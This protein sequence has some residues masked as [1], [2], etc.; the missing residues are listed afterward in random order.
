MLNQPAQSPPPAPHPLPS[1]A[2]ELA[3]FTVRDSDLKV[4]LVQREGLARPSL[5]GA[6][7]HL[8]EGPQDQ[9]EDLDDTARRALVE[10]T[11][12]PQA[13]VYLEQLGAFGKPGRDPSSRVISVAFELLPETFTVA[14][15]REVYEAVFG[16]T[17]DP[18]NFRRRFK[19]LLEDGVVASA[20]GRRQT[21]SKPAAVFRYCGPA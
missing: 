15:L 20:P 14:E 2:A 7:V 16:A 1:V 10:Q 17:Y 12:L 21:R 9:G 13:S 3:V 11:G 4:L 5:P 6:T 19:R 18:A 8:G